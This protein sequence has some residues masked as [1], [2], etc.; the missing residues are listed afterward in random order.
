M[1]YATSKVSD[2]SAINR[3]AVYLL[4]TLRLADVI[5][6]EIGDVKS[7]EISNLTVNNFVLMVCGPLHERTLVK[8]ILVIQV[9]IV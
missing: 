1:S 9:V 5:Y 6:S 8:V 3:F 4:R 7:I 2:L